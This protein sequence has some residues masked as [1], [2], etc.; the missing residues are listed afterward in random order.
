E[1]RQPE[2]RPVLFDSAPCAGIGTDPGDRQHDQTAADND[3]KGEE[4]NHHRRP[5][6]G[7]KIGQPD[8]LGIEAHASDQT[9]KN[10]YRDRVFV[11]LSHGVGNGY[12]DFAGRFLIVPAALDSCELGR[13]IV[14]NVVP[15]EMSKKDLK[16][17]QYGSKVQAHAEHDAALG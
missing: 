10:R 11:A 4:R 7:W 6:L 13:L 2:Q 5:V 1:K 3:A 9:A 12:Y 17:D 8:L 14:V 15:V 16:G